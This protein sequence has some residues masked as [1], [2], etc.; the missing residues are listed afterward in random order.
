MRGNTA[1]NFVYEWLGLDSAE[2]GYSE[3]YSADKGASRD[4]TGPA[5]TGT[6]AAMQ[7]QAVFDAIA[8]LG[9]ELLDFYL[10]VDDGGEVTRLA[11]T[12]DNGYNVDHSGDFMLHFTWETSFVGLSTSGISVTI[13]SADGNS[14]I[15]CWENSNLVLL[16][17]D[18]EDIWMT[19][20]PQSDTQYNP[21]PFPH[22]GGQRCDDRSND[23][24]DHY[25]RRSH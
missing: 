4:D 22:R 14:W 7:A 1:V 5:I 15:Q 18:G 12:Q 10:E 21:V 2:I 24:W 20:T 6:D 8:G 17:Q 9:D 19:A 25:G 11:I 16:H 13:Q 23:L 3:M